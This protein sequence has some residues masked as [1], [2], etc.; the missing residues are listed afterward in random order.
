M[1]TI[2]NLGN[3]TVSWLRYRDIHLL[4]HGVT[5]YT[6]D[7]RFSAYMDILT[8]T[9]QLRIKNVS[10]SDA[11]VYECQVSTTPH[12]SLVLNLDV[13]EPEVRILGGPDMFVDTGSI[14]NLTC[15]ISWTPEPPRAT[16][17]QH[18]LSTIS[19]RGPRPGVSLLVDKSEVTTVQLIMMSARYSDSGQYTCSPDNGPQAQLTLH[20]LTGDKTAKL[21]GA[22]GWRPGLWGSLL[23]VSLASAL[24]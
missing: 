10:T 7:R 1:C 5:S 4:T 22:G 14:I 18:N 6:D 19:F 24:S 11:G 9:W 13:R 21:S 20:V 8:N 23:A 16:L 15:V 12:R 17:W 3:R 2:T